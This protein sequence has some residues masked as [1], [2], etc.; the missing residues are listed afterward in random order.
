MENNIGDRKI[1]RITTELTFRCNSQCL[2]CARKKII[3]NNC[4]NL[5]D[6]KYT[7]TLESFQTMFPRDFLEQVKII[8][9]SGIFGDSIMCP[10]FLHIIEYIKS[11]GCALDMSTNGAAHDEEFWIKLGNLLTKKDRIDFC[12][13]GLSDTHSIYRVGTSYEKIIKNAKAIIATKK[14]RVSW[15]FIVFSHNEHQ[16]DEAKSLA[17]TLGF[18]QFMI[19]HNNRGK[20]L[21]T[22]KKYLHPMYNHSLFKRVTSKIKALLITTKIVCKGPKEFYASPEGLIFKCCYADSNYY[23]KK[24]DFTYPKDIEEKF[25]ALKRPIWDIIN[26]PYWQESFNKTCNKDTA[27]QLCKRYCTK[28]ETSCTF[29]GIVKLKNK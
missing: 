23:Y 27:D 26:D 29:V 28:N 10:D 15:K 11:C 2:G 7:Q 5:N 16:V 18:T 13:D 12:I 1:N 4:F 25:N 9:L 21:P 19:K 20:L 24:I 8:Y 3:D 6:Q 14:T 22:N 17:K